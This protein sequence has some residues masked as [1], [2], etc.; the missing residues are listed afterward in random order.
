M[1]PPSGRGAPSASDDVESVL[2]EEN[3]QDFLTWLAI[4]RGRAQNTLESYRR[5]LLRYQAHLGRRGV[6]MATAAGDDIVA[7][8]HVLVGSGLAAS[9]VKRTLVAV[10]GLH[11]FLVAEEMRLDDPSVD[12]E[13]PQV[14]RG[15][16]TIG[17][18]G[19]TGRS[20][21]RSTAPGRGSRSW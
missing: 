10:R 11:R 12:V 17:W 3:A 15:R 14:P 9:S 4:E 5:D 1:D 8:V 20:S 2:L 18:R 16:V 6:G 19:A 13:I 7:F 21:R